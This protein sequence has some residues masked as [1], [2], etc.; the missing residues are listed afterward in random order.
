MREDWGLC[1][2]SH[3]CTGWLV[4]FHA[5]FE[6]ITSEA[7]CLRSLDIAVEH[8]QL[9]SKLQALLGGQERQWLFSKLADVREV[10]RRFLADLEEDLEQDI[11][12]FDVCGIFLS[13][14]PD[15]R[16]VYIPYVTNQSYQEKTFKRLIRDNPQFREVVEELESD[17]LCQRLSLKSFLI[18]PFQRITRLKLLVQNILKRSSPGSHEECKASKAFESLA[19][20]SSPS[21]TNDLVVNASPRMKG[22][23]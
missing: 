13:H 5:K 16:A 3:R 20:V 1:L 7:S 18:L 14:L 2:S 6:L 21:G 23:S 4:K 9:S 8:F 10:S 22:Q 19:E 11:M 12:E 17:P 15:F